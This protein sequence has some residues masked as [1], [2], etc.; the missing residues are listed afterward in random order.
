[1]KVVGEWREIE[2][3]GG[4][5][6]AE[7]K[8]SEKGDNNVLFTYSLPVFFCSLLSASFLLAEQ[9]KKANFCGAPPPPPVY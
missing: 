9:L 3:T 4:G 7:E 2:V 5:E 1:M 6:G 8:K